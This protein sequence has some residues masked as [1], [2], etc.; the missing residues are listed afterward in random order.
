MIISLAPATL[1]RGWSPT[2]LS[3]GVILCLFWPEAA[4]RFFQASMLTR[5]FPGAV[6]SYVAQRNVM[7]VD[8][9]GSSRLVPASLQTAGGARVPR[10]TEFAGCR[11]ATSVPLTLGETVDSAGTG[12]TPS[13]VSRCCTG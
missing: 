6:T 2:S 12:A 8:D 4:P 9:A 13:S 5:V 1:L 10:F 11:V 7:T 3:C